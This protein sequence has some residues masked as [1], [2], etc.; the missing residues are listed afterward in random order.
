MRRQNEGAQAGDLIDVVGVPKH[1]FRDLYHRLLRASWPQVI[2]FI[3]LIFV[4]VNTLFATL[5]FEI[6]GISATGRASWSDAFFFSVQTF[7]TIGYGVLNPQTFWANVAVS[8]ES[9]VSLLA[10]ALS[11]GL[12]FQRFSQPD[13]QVVFANRVCIAPFEGVATLMLRIGNDRTDVIVNADVQVDAVK[14][15]LT[16]EG[17]TIYRTYPL[18]LMRARAST[19][20]RTWMAMHVIQEGSPLFNMTPEDAKKLELELYVSVTGMDETTHQMVHGRTRYLDAE[21]AWGARPADLLTE[22]PNGR[23]QLNVAKFDEV[24]PTQA[25]P[26]FPFPVSAHPTT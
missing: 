18:T 2:V 3:A 20:S 13:S 23:L 12:V 14:T 26:E 5:Y 16:R 17:Q 1:P 9:I 22:L 24:V 25:T 19:L 6:G 15:T 10:T 4:A 7:G 8:V 11:T 21:I